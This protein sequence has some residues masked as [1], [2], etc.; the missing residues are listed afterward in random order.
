MRVLFKNELVEVDFNPKMPQLTLTAYYV[1]SGE[2]LLETD[3]NDLWERHYDLISEEA[4]SFVLG[5]C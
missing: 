3:I 4:R 2:E 5:D 1:D